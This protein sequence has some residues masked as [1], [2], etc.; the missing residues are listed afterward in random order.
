MSF[1]Y[2]FHKHHNLSL[3]KT[4]FEEKGLSGLVNVGNTCFM[5]SILQ[6]LSHT[7]KM[8]DFFLSCQFKNEDK[9]HLNVRR[10]EW[11]FV[12]CYLNLVIN[13]WESNGVLKPKSFL[14]ALCKFEPKYT[15]RTQQD[16]HECLLHILDILHK[17]LS[18]EIIVDIIGEVENE[19]DKLMKKSIECWTECFK[20]N[21]SSI[22]DFFYGQVFDAIQC[23]KC[24]AIDTV[25][26]PYNTL[27]VDICGDDLITCL[28]EYF[29]PIDIRTWRC[30]QPNCSGKEEVGCCKKTSLWTLPNYL[31]I[32]LKRFNNNN[33]KKTDLVKF[34]LED[35]DLTEYISKE[36]EDP[37]N[38]IYTL[39][40]VN[41]HSGSTN[42][43]HYWSACRGIN[44]K[45]FMFNDADVSR[46]KSSDI[47]SKDA[48]IL[49]YYRK[50]IT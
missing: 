35:L 33:S 12:M 4:R 43:G 34:P 48:Y 45:W 5:N 17:G 31:I 6:C 26:T 7:L 15:P 46:C 11:K 47:V 1:S 38:Y 32:Q 27:A 41:Y 2:D 18:Y 23:K 8:T 24:C 9:E 19:A 16:S 39:Y 3:A 20:K 29:N 10:E 37:N 44:D 13:L 40:A 22:V 28:G 49:F 25:F 14:N 36:K 21:Y 50:F 30:E 42:S